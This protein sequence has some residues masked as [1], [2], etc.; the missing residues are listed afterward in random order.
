M[1]LVKL[2]PGA[3]CLK[4]PRQQTEV[5]IGFWPDGTPPLWTCRS[6]ELDFGDHI[7]SYRKEGYEYYFFVYHRK[8][9]IRINYNRRK[10]NIIAKS[11]PYED[12]HVPNEFRILAMKL[13]IL[14]IL[15]E[16]NNKI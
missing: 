12:N 16:F 11:R 9:D 1:V 3:W 4:E 15:I 7:G 8:Y 6:G 2:Q 13:I 10:S 14:K 5:Q